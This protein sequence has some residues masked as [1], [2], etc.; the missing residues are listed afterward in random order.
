MNRYDYK[1]N[2]CDNFSLPANRLLYRELGEYDAMVEFMECAL[3]YM[4]KHEDANIKLND[5][6]ADRIIETGIYLCDFSVERFLTMARRGYLV[7]PIACMN[8]Y[9]ENLTNDVKALFGNEEVMEEQETT[10]DKTRKKTKETKKNSLGKIVELLN[11]IDID[12]K[13]DKYL[14]AIYDYYNKLRNAEAHHN[15]KEQTKEAIEELYD[16]VTAFQSDIQQRFPNQKTGIP[17]AHGEINFDDFI[18]CTATIKIIA[19]E[20]ER[21][22]KSHISIPDVKEKCEKYLSENNLK[23][24]NFDANRK[25]NYIAN[26]I[27]TEYGIII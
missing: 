3:R 21:T 19:D 16:I 4:L 9:L 25:E 14:V 11:S 12:I 10:G 13:I 6:L 15:K 2:K 7:F 22:I 20:V 24:K 17:H 18:L 8:A 26:Y 1:E 27:Q 23:N 5:L